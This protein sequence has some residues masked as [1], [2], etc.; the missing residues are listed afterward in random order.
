[1]EAL[2]P[3]SS[4]D[5]KLRSSVVTVGVSTDSRAISWQ[6][7][8]EAQATAA[9]MFQHYTSCGVK[10]YLYVWG[11]PRPRE[12]YTPVCMAQVP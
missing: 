7:L 5:V 12:T 9:S 11:L 6:R 8:A 2:P 3:N 4:R 1:M 10:C